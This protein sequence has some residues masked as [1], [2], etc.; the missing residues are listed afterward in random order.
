MQQA[1]IAIQDGPALAREGAS[2]SGIS[3]RGYGALSATPRGG[4]SRNMRVL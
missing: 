4:G 2:K 1:V 3:P